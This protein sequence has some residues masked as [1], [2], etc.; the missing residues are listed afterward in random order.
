MELRPNH[1]HVAVMWD[2]TRTVMMLASLLHIGTMWDYTKTAMM[3]CQI[4]KT[5]TEPQYGRG[6]CC[7]LRNVISYSVAISSNARGSHWQRAIQLLLVKKSCNLARVRN[8]FGSQLLAN[9][10][11]V[12][13]PRRRR[14]PMM[15]FPTGEPKPLEIVGIKCAYIYMYI[16][17]ICTHKLWV[18]QGSNH[19]Q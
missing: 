15:R 7:G 1:Q 2:S 13:R 9:A 10:G 17:I 18:L 19:Q 6:I 12:S 5:S 3:L 11:L 14:D 16:C 8:P 4:R